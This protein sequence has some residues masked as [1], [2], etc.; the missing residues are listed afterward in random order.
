MKTLALRFVRLAVF[1]VAATLVGFA[2]VHAQTN[3]A[4][5][6]LPFSLTS[7]TGSTLPAGVAVHRFGTT[8][9]TIPTTRTVVPATGDLPYSSTSNAGGW[10][11]EAS[12]AGIGILASGSQ[13]AGALVVAINTTGQTAIQVFW[14]C[15]TILQ[16]ASR[17]NS[18]A[19]QYRVGTSG[20]FIDVGTGTTY[21]SAGKTAGDVSATLTETLPVGAENQPVV[22]VRWIYWESVST[23][24]SRDRIAI[25]DIT[26][27]ANSGP[28]APAV[29]A[30]SPTSGATSVGITSPI[31]ITFNQAVTVTG[32]WFGINS[33][34]NGAVNAIASGGPTTFTLTPAASFANSD[35]I[36]VTVFAAQVTD[37]ATG[38]LQPAANTNF[39]FTTAAPPGATTPIH[40][41]QGPGTATPIANQTVTV[42]G[43]VTG[44]Y[45]NG[46][47]TRDGFY[48]QE[49]DADADLDP[50]T[51]EGLYV[52]A[53]TSPAQTSAVAA[54]AVGDAVT[55]SGTAKEFSNLTQIDTLTAVT[56]TG[57]APLPAAI[58][59]NLPVASTTFMERYEGMRVTFSQ[60]LT[61]TNTFALGQYG[62]FEASIGGRLPEPTNIVAPGTAANAQQ[63]INDRSFITVD[64]GTSKTYPD[65]TPYLFGGATSTENTLRGGDTV[66][67]ITGIVTYIAG[68]YMVEPSAAS[69]FTRANPRPA[70]PAVGGTLRVVGTNVLNYFNGNG[71]GGGFPT[72]RGAD[73][74]AELARQRAHILNKL[75]ALNADVYGLT[76]VENDGFGSASAIQDLVNGLN[77][78]APS[79][80]VYAFSDPGVGAIGTDAITCAFIYKTNTLA[81]VGAAV[82][83][84]ASIFNRPPLAQTFRQISNNEKFTVCVNHF[85]S[86]GSGSATGLDL[87]QGDGQAAYNARRTSQANTLTAWLATNPTG[88]ADPDILIIGDLNAYSKEDP[89]TA[90]KNAGYTNLVE[91][92]EGVGGYSY[93]FGGQ[94][95]HLDH[96]LSTATLATQITGAESWHCNADEPIILDYNIDLTS[97]LNKSAAQLLLNNGAGNDGNTPWRAS[98]HD[99]VVIGLNLAPPP[100]APVITLQ[101]LVQTVTV[102]ANVTFTVAAS[103]TPAPTFQWRK[104]GVAI[105][106][107]AS[108][109]TATLTLNNVTTADAG[110]YSAV[111]TNSGGSATSAT[112]TLTVNQAVAT[113]TLGSLS[114]TYDTFGKAATATTL[115][116][117]LTVTFTYDGG[118]TLPVAAGSYAVV[119]TVNDANYTG[120]ATGTLSI[121]QASQ[122]I[123]FAALASTPLTS[124][125]INLTG[126]ASSGLPVTFTSDNPA[127]ATV[128]GDVVTLVAAGTANITAAQAGNGN[129]SAAIS[130]VRSLEVTSGTGGGSPSAASIPT[131]P[132]WGLIALALALGGLAV[133]RLRAV[134]PTSRR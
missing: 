82:V 18:A 129:Y 99:P 133:R 124:G 39:S 78:L 121:S 5:Q 79:G 74:A 19:L 70:P 123:S 12:G 95:G 83:N 14:L 71:A 47:G 60:T 28:A 56:K 35:A 97:S 34:A 110:G 87:D 59:V 61:V 17:D 86:K 6:S 75:T 40:A 16:Q 10:R 73:T 116:A 96:A 3:P 33:T 63:A 85:K 53:A 30:T 127:V 104:G 98:D 68:I 8:S 58:G 109:T 49:P 15:R 122:S 62:Q 112:V 91:Q 108:A 94:F 26:I 106:G 77:A 22:Q 23:S 128:A 7:Q 80:T 52:Y 37:Q 92:Y 69:S 13:S 42:D 117:G 89:I 31:T 55:V 1:A 41:V 2:P 48:L 25:D 93:T 130:V 36:S 65:P 118:A 100:V 21:T 29:V 45:T 57:T 105:A 81:P 90:I 103:G 134:A 9:G 46:S 66:T 32:A 54:L 20:N 101:P 88:D 44:F 111:A 114:A 51:S 27:T 38:L 76:E 107:N 126:T 84:T 115:P 132:E 24:G 72:A 119:A 113:V 50:L 67:G 11:D 125:T 43:I 4:A 131:L 102:G 64:D 120:S